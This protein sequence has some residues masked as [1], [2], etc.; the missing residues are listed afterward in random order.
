MNPEK[1]GRYVLIGV[2]P[3]L[4]PMIDDAR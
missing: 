4:N 3:Q 1:D 2:E